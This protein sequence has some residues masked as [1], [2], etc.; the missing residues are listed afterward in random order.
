MNQAPTKPGRNARKAKVP[1]G[2]LREIWDK[3]SDEQRQAV[4]EEQV[5][6]ARAGK[7][8]P[9]DPREEARHARVMRRLRGRPKIGQGSKMIALSIELGLLGR[10]DA[11]AK[12]HGLSRA[13]AV[14][15]IVNGFLAERSARRKSRAD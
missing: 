3:L 5:A 15:L 1:A 11:F 8:S 10:L 14:S 13:A 4:I 2:P 9:A 12:D 7:T 6:A